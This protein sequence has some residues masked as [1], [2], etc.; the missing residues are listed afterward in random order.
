MTRDTLPRINRTGRVGA[1]RNVDACDL[2][3]LESSADIRWSTGFGG[4]VSSLLLDPG[5]ARGHLLV[6]ARYVERAEAEV[7]AASAEVDVV[8]VAPQRGVDR[9]LADLA[10][11]RT[12]GVD[13]HTTTLARMR[14]LAAVVAVTEASSPLADLRRVKSHEEIAVMELAAA[15][16]TEALL[17][18]VSDGLAGRTEREIRS[19]LDAKMLELGA[20]GPAF[21]TI[22]A[23]GPRAARPH[24]EAGDDRVAADDMVVIDMGA[25]IG[26]YRSDMTRVVGVGHPDAERAGML[27]TVS[28]AQASGVSTVRAGVV[29]SEVD[30]AVRQV[31]A[32]AGCESEFVHGTGHGVGIDIHETPVL[33][34][35]CDAVLREGEV[36]TVEPGLYR[37]GVGGVR[38]EDLVV[39]GADGCRN[40]TLA[41]K[42][43]SCPRS[44][45]TT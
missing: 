41:P 10:A 2:L 26:G 33:G 12:I 35:R 27:A 45:P 5:T 15:I 9:M 31:L 43:L 24:H 21:A 44:R 11:G 3:L 6:D 40:L 25:E 36:V 23:A 29:G 8:A 4:S 38:I 22:V 7:G 37:V 14:R 17:S 28:E 20:D 1:V 19:R 32:A 18:V 13:P 16:A 34:P 30:S 42:E 39:V